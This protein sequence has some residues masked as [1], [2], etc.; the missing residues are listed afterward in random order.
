MDRTTAQPHDS[1]QN[2]MFSG[3]STRSDPSAKFWMWFSM[4]ALALAA[5]L[6]V[7]MTWHDPELTLQR[8]LAHGPLWLLAAGGSLTLAIVSLVVWSTRD[9]QCNH[10][11]T[12]MSVTLSALVLALLFGRPNVPF[13]WLASTLAVFSFANL[14]VM[15]KNK[16]LCG[17][18]AMYKNSRRRAA[19]R[20]DDVLPGE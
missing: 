8:L 4:T 16:C 3:F 7:A 6:V 13:Q 5:A 18:I 12:V 9:F 15:E 11:R 1:M 14:I 10:A 19:A 20:R 17:W 2:A